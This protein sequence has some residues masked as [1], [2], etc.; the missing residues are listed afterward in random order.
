MRD[1]EAALTCLPTVRAQVGLDRAIGRWTAMSAPRCWRQARKISSVFW[2]WLY[3][4]SV[5]QS[6]RAIELRTS[7]RPFRRTGTDRYG[8]FCCGLDEIALIADGIPVGCAGRRHAA[9]SASAIVLVSCR[10]RDAVRPAASSAL[11]TPASHTNT[12]TRGRWDA[13]RVERFGLTPLFPPAVL[14]RAFHRCRRTEQNKAIRPP[15]FSITVAIS[16]GF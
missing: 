2:P 9:M 10:P 6:G 13:A 14:L 5:E 3:A 12:A 16:E 4:P 1:I 8:V 15:R 7:R 11:A